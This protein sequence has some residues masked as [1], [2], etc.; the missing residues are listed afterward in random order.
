MPRPILL[1]TNGWID[2]P[3]ADLAAKAAEWGYDGLELACLGDHVEVQRA[4][5]EPDYCS[6]MLD[7]L[8]RHDL[9]IPILSNHRVGQAVCDAIDIRHK[10]LLPD[11]VWGDGQPEGVR[12]RAAEEMAATLRVAQKLG[13]SLVGGFT[14]SNLWSQVAGYPGP[15]PDGVAAG[16]RE[17][18]KLWNPILDVGRETGVRFAFEVHPGQMAFDY[19]SAEMVLDVLHGRE[20]FGFTFDPSHFHW[21]GVDPVEFIRR[22]GDRIYHVHIKDCVLTLN[23]RSGVLNSYLPYGDPR[24]GWHFRAPGRGG[25]D[26]EGVIRA[27]N[28]AG[29]AGA[30]SVEFHDRDMNRE[31]GAEEARRFVKSLDFEP[32]QP[33]GPQAFK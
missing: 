14:G 21:Q 20:E 29:Y 8:S 24:R 26:W 27:L 23:G 16:L 9:Q 6:A 12:H 31:F 25:I 4:L 5:S 30:L 28:A 7:L 22:F 13:A 32:A 17:F 2:L 33:P 15:T 10:T 11:Y 1:F 18:A 3:L 19:Y